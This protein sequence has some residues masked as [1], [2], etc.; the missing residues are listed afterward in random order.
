M[1]LM[2]YLAI[3]KLWRY[4]AHLRQSQLFFVIQ[5]RDFSL[6]SKWQNR[7]RLARH[8][9]ATTSAKPPT[10][11]IRRHS[12]H[13]Q[14]SPHTHFGEAPPYVIRRRSRSSTA[15][16]LCRR[17]E[18]LCSSLSPSLRACDCGVAIHLSHV[19]FSV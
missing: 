3:V 11:V 9:R 10:Y 19:L 18:H 2:R 1:L 15:S 7:M 12:H 14:Q 17:R 8:S 16:W 4:C 5:N 13:Y 6:R